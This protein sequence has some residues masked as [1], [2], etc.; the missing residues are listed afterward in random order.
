[1]IYCG[2]KAVAPHGRPTGTEN[3]CI[4]TRQLRLYGVHKARTYDDDETEHVK[5]LISRQGVYCGGKTSS[6]RG[7]H[8]RG[9]YCQS[10]GQL[11]LYGRFTLPTASSKSSSRESSSSSQQNKSNLSPHPL[12]SNSQSKHNNNRGQNSSRSRGTT[13]HSRRNNVENRMNNNNNNPHPVQSN[14]N[15]NQGQKSRGT[16]SSGTFSMLEDL[17]SDDVGSKSNSS[18]HLP[19]PRRQ[20]PNRTNTINRL[21][22]PSGPILS[23]RMRSRATSSR[24]ASNHSVAKSARVAITRAATNA[25]QKK[26]K[27]AKNAAKNDRLANV[28]RSARVRAS[29]YAFGTRTFVR[30]VVRGDGNCLFNAFAHQLER[31]N[32]RIT[33]GVLRQMTVNR[34]QKDRRFRAGWYPTADIPTFGKYLSLMRQNGQANDEATY[35]DNMCLHALASIFRVRVLLFY[36]GS[37]TSTEFD[38]MILRRGESSGQ[39]EQSSEP[40]VFLVYSNERGGHYDST[41][42]R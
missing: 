36:E 30:H 8:A 32:V 13:S 20:P 25:A 21:P 10:R 5:G 15:N 35:G 19:K 7:E 23:P 33:P 31:L 38:P 1:M 27:A 16:S 34:L 42:E 22:S 11:R 12:Q 4:G 18:L 14:H 37:T 39:S 41:N 6:T 3:Q 9:D 17:I 29:D 26:A 28:R 24:D 2:A 40:T